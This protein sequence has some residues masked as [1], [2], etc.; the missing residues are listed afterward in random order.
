MRQ[1]R[2]KDGEQSRTWP[3]KDGVYFVNG[4]PVTEYTGPRRPGEYMNRHGV[5]VSIQTG[6]V[7]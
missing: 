3:N 4:Y 5:N 2:L 6:D 7:S 1:P